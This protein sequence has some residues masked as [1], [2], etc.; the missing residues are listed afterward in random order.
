MKSF[1]FDINQSKRSNFHFK[2]Q[3]KVF[4]TSIDM[5]DKKKT[6]FYRNCFCFLV[7]GLCVFVLNNSMSFWSECVSQ[8]C[9]FPNF[10]FINQKLIQP[11]MF[12]I[13][14][15]SERTLPIVRYPDQGSQC[16]ID[17]HWEYQFGFFQYQVHLKAVFNHEFIWKNKD[18]SLFKAIFFSE[19]KQMQIW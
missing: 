10:V 12:C 3:S 1:F 13:F 2:K 18:F 15:H 8:D 16:Q 9:N 14:F 4:S 5:T 19:Q 7:F 17:H 6:F 11:W